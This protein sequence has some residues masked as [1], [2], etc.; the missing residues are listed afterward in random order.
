MSQNFKWKFDE[1]EE[2]DNSPKD[3]VKHYE[4][5]SFARS[6]CFV[7][8]DG[9]MLFLYY[10]YLVSGDFMP[11]ENKITLAFT[12]HSV[13]LA[14]VKLESL[15]FDL[16]RHMPKNIICVDARYNQVEGDKAIVNVIDIEKL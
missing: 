9:S 5:E 16:M 6:V 8:L 15:F 13:T 14:G 7:M 4:A 11:E 3:V 2:N 10:T 1:L 12:S